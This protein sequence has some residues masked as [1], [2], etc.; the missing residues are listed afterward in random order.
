VTDSFSQALPV[1]AMSTTRVLAF[2]YDR[3]LVGVR[4]SVLRHSGY[5]VEETFSVT[6]AL[7]R[8]QSDSIDAILICHSVPDNGVEKLVTAVRKTR[9]LMP[10]LCMR[11]HP[12]GLRR[13][14][15]FRLRTPR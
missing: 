4:T 3:T 9:A 1:P 8:A 6:E 2:G 11:T 15:V 12:F 7:K 14:A 10:I 13:A 5:H